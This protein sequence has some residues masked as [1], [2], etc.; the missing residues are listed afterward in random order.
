MAK[1]TKQPKVVARAKMLRRLQDHFDEYSIA[2]VMPTDPEMR[3][4]LGEI[5][6]VDQETSEVLDVRLSLETL[7]KECKVM[8]DHEVL[9][10][11]DRPVD[12]GYMGTVAELCQRL[13]NLPPE[14]NLALFEVLKAFADGAEP[15]KVEDAGDIN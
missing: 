10:P 8:A 9:A 3:I 2:V 7:A 12:E 4:L 15:P 13:R 5:Y 14:R 6:I 11:D 1:K